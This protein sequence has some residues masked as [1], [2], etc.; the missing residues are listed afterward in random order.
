[1]QQLRYRNSQ[2]R[3]SLIAASAM[4]FALAA[5]AV[6]VASLMSSILP[7]WLVIA[8]AVVPLFIILAWLAPEFTA[9]GL[10]AALFGVLPDFLLPSLPIGG[11]ELKPEDLGMPTLLLLLLLKRA[12]SLQLRLAPMRAYWLPLGLFILVALISA[13]TALAYKTAPA[14]DIFNESRPYFTWMLL[15]IFCL[16]IDT[17]K[18]LKRFLILLMALA[19]TLATGVMFQSFTGIAIFGRGQELRQ[20]WSI[21]G[22]VSDVLRSTTPGMFLMTGALIYLF[23]AYAKEQLRQPILIALLGAI[24]TGGLLVGFGRGMWLSLIIGLALL[25]FF[26]RRASYFQL[27]LTC[28]AMATLVVSTLLIAK[29]E[30]LYAI[31][32]RFLSVGEEI[33]SGSSFGRRKEENYYAL[34]KIAESPLVGVGLGGRYKPDS[35]ESRTWPDQVRYV[36]NAY[37]KVAVKTGIPGILTASFLIIVLVGRSWSAARSGGQNPAVSF[38]VLWVILTTTIFTS[39]TQPNFVASN[40]VASIALAVFLS[41]ALRGKI[42]VQAKSGAH[43]TKPRYATHGS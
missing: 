20:L 1:M 10:L 41:E 35:P 31:S 19:L 26:S 30:Y 36:H 12:G 9:I 7:W 15:P 43:A 6:L 42:G 5:F 33:E 18:R 24:L 8:I 37:V 4:Q 21:D 39:M 25:A 28:T 34:Q 23:A 16:A 38:A 3:N 32:D 22:G 17:E 40:G 14:K 29:P 2:G 11:G 13:I 27:V